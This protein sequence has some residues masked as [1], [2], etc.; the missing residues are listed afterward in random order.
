MV[1]AHRASLVGLNKS[2]R[3]DAMR[4]LFY[5]CYRLLV[6]N[7]TLTVLVNHGHP[8]YPPRCF[9]RSS[10]RVP[11][12]ADHLYSIR[13]RPF[14]TKDTTSN[15]PRCRLYLVLLPFI[16][17]L[18]A[19]HSVPDPPPP[20]DILTNSQRSQKTIPTNTYQQKQRNEY[21]ERL[22][23]DRFSTR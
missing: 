10:Y 12:D 11:V 22:Q 14:C 19:V 23:N 18:R 17:V 15:L 1:H 20:I 9:L 8:S 21:S 2:R 13:V 7:H 4:Y 5:Y 16:P 6:L 3:T